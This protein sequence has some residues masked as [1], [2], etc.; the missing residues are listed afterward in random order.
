MVIIKLKK[1]L[2]LED[3]GQ[4]VIFGIWKKAEIEKIKQYVTIFFHQV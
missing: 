3:F 2:I 1:L 4:N